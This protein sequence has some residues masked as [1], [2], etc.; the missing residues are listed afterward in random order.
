MKRLLNILRKSQDPYND[1]TKLY[2]R[3]ILKNICPV[4][5]DLGYTDDGHKNNFYH[6]MTV[7][8]NVCDA[9]GDFNMKVVALFHDIGKPKTKRVNNKNTWSFHGHESLGAEMFKKLYK[10]HDLDV[11]INYLYRMIKNHGRIKIHRD[12][13]D[14]AIRRLDKDVGQD[15]IFDVIDFSIYDITTKYQSKRERIISSLKVIRKR[16]LEVRELDE[17]N[18]WRSPLTGHVIM[19]IVPD[20]TG[21]EIGKIKKKY[22]QAFRDGK[23]TLEE[24]INEIKKGL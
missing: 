17:Y 19:E 9:D 6:T 22:E 21:E 20:I 24:A 13:S 10:E 5:H 18:A 4:L 15:I 2:E 3:G 8:K 16:I 23:I 12:V 1:I 11:D 7:L 14:S